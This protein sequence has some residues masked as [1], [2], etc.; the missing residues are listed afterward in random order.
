MILLVLSMQIWYNLESMEHFFRKLSILD[1]L[2]V[3]MTNHRR[4]FKTFS[5]F[6]FFG[7]TDL[8]FPPKTI[9]KL[10]HMCFLLCLSESKLNSPQFD[11]RQ[12][13]SA[14]RDRL[15]SEADWGRSH[16]YFGCDLVW[17]FHMCRFCSRG[18]WVSGL[19][20]LI[21]YHWKADES[22]F[23]IFRWIAL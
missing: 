7:C 12:S 8:R 6:R 1:T 10:F 20:W 13:L 17:W 19:D 22:I 15:I 23:L 2:L 11:V 9:T 21:W 16:V 3:G 18:E 4:K 14:Q 5:H